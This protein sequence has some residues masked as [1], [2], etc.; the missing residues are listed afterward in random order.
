MDDGPKLDLKKKIIDEQMAEFWKFANQ[1]MTLYHE[2]ALSVDS[3]VVPDSL[4]EF[5]DMFLDRLSKLVQAI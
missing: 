3:M 1:S 5:S 4:R 2:S